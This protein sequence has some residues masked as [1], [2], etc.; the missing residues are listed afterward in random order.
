VYNGYELSAAL[1]MAGPESTITLA[2]GHFGDVGHFILNNAKIS[3]R[4]QS[5][6]QTVLQ[7]PLEVNA[8]GVELDDL[9]FGSGLLLTGTGL[10]IS[11][12]L[13]RG[14][15]VSVTGTG[16]EVSYCEFSDFTGVGVRV[17]NTARKA[18][19][20]HNYFHD[21]KGTGNGHE[22]VQVAQSL[23]DT[24]KELNALIEYNLFERCNAESETIS[25]K[26][27]S[28]IIRF[29]TLQDSESNLVNRHGER[30]TWAGNTLIRALT[31]TIHDRGNKV[32][33]NRLISSRQIRV[34]G[35]S[36]TPDTKKEKGKKGGHPQAMDTYLCGNEGGLEIG[37]QFKNLK[38]PAV[39]TSVANHK[40]S[41]KLSAQTGTNLNALAISVPA[42][43]QV[44]R[45][46]V[47]PRS[48]TAR[49]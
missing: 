31:I 38:L 36:I 43:V 10:K 33:G 49:A 48:G 27:S 46:E 3:I 4:V 40:G 35:G 13:F 32:L 14:N 47:G 28:N 12:S 18:F 17:Q 34:M 44:S 26:S 22:A 29:N 25:V 2:P 45:A 24:D 1:Q 6:L 15:G 21:S 11:N 16:T 19:V 5:P 30:N 42:A 20:H 7:A 41:I 37:Y 8:N 39:N 23:N 9:V